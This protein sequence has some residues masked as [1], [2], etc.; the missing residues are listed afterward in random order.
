MP[1]AFL[2]KV[3]LVEAAVAKRRRFKR[4]SVLPNTKSLVCLTSSYC[5]RL[6]GTSLKPCTVLRMLRSPA[7]AG[8]A[9]CGDEIQEKQCQ[10][11]R[12]AII[13]S[14]ESRVISLPIA[15]PD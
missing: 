2:T 6:G 1:G 12:I 10:Q 8:K 11:L 13:V 14:A 4:V 3:D 5:E 9:G 7:S 15:D